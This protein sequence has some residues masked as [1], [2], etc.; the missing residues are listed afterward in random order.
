MA[1][2]GPAP[3]EPF[4]LET[5]D[6]PRFCLYHAPASPCHASL[7]YLHPLAEEMNRSRQMAALQARAFAAAGIAVL[8]LDLHGC[9]DSGGEFADASWDDWLRDVAASRA[10]LEQRSGHAAGLWGLRLGALLALDAAH[11]ADTAPARLLLWQPVTDGAA[12][13]NQFLRLRMAADMLQGGA[14]EDGKALRARLQAGETL[15]VAGYGLTRSLAD[16]IDAAAVGLPAPPCPVHW[17]ELAA[18]E[19]RP[20]SP[21]A[22]RIAEQWR[23]AGVDV[24]Q[25]QVVGPPFWS[26]PEL[27]RA[28]ALI[29]ASLDGF[30]ELLHV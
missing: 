22:V 30:K 18:Q 24:K 7:L 28:P 16:G 4:Y 15:E 26:T 23:A 12:H 3:A 29:Q 27:T 1:R 9:G 20:L 21:A 17:L 10:W 13:L 14:R 6:G 2:F 5:A 11:R 25:Q 8:L 19:G